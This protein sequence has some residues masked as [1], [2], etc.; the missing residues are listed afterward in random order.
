M[1]DPKN[2]QPTGEEDLR[3]PSPYKSVPTLTLPGVAAL[4]QPTGEAAR[5]TTEQLVGLYNEWF[6]RTPL[7]DRAEVQAFIAGYKAAHPAQPQKKE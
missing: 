4:I 6:E 5:L 7:E 1:T 3:Q 2:P